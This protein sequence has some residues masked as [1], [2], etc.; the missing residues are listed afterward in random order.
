MSRSCRLSPVS[1]TWFG[2]PRASGFRSKGGVNQCCLTCCCRTLS[3]SLSSSSS[4]SRLLSCSAA[5]AGPAT[6]SCND[7]SASSL[8]VQQGA[9]LRAHL[10]LSAPPLHLRQP[11]V[12]GHRE[13][14]EV[15]AAE[16]LVHVV[17]LTEEDAAAAVLAGWRKTSPSWTDTPATSTCSPRWYLQT[18]SP[19]CRTRLS[20]HRSHDRPPTPALQSHLP[21]SRSHAGCREPHPEQLHGRHAPPGREGLP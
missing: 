6:S 9:V 20:S 18:Q 5:A 7:S 4:S 2:E 11:Q 21:L 15:Q 13:A 3:F 8:R 12:R 16:T 14:A 17:Q 1:T 10:D 19:S